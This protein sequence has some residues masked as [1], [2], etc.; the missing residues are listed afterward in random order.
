MS[1]NSDLNECE[2]PDLCPWEY[3]LNTQGGYQCVSFCSTGY[4]PD[5]NGGCVGQF[6]GFHDF[7]VISFV[8]K[9]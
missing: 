1:S 8:K 7:S 2:D 4:E 5:T 3:C 9:L 6:P